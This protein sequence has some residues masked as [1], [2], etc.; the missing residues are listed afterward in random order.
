MNPLKPSL[1]PLFVQDYPY[2]ELSGI[3]F[4]NSEVTILPMDKFNEKENRNSITISEKSK[5][6]D[7]K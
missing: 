6:K 7:Y 3:S 2:K 1:V 5:K 4:Q